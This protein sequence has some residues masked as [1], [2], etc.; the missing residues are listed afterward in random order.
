ML[1]PSTHPDHPR[2]TTT[3]HSEHKPTSNKLPALTSPEKSMIVPSWRYLPHQTLERKSF[4]LLLRMPVHNLAAETAISGM[5]STS[6]SVRVHSLS[7]F[8]A[9]LEVRHILGRHLHLD[10]RLGISRLAWR[11]VI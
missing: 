4:L 6:I 7:H 3:A 9:G 10:T 8:L 11:L 1:H 5:D 2:N